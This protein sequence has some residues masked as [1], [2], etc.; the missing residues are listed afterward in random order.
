MPP[1]GTNGG[2]I[3][4]GCTKTRLNNTYTNY[5]PT[6]QIKTSMM[7]N[8]FYLTILF[9][10]TNAGCTDM[11]SSKNYRYTVKNDSDYNIKVLSYVSS[12]VNITPIATIINKGEII[13]K[14]HESHAPYN[15]SLNFIK[16]FGD[17][18]SDSYDSIT[19][20][21]NNE[22]QK[23]FTDQYDS[24]RN[25]LNISIYHNLEETFVFTN[26]DYENAEDCGGPCE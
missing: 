8:I 13:T 11:S 14:T 18:D 2:I 16:F 22:R 20:T 19:I 23:I 24:N 17:Y 1:L 6:G 10:F 26:E 5:L 3:L 7:K 12:N 25:P 21:Y 4:L 9:L 15:S